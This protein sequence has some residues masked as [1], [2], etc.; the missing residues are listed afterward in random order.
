MGAESGT[1]Q[2]PPGDSK[3]SDVA[4]TEA[5]WATS[6]VDRAVARAT[7]SSSVRK[8]PSGVSWFTWSAIGLNRSDTRGGKGRGSKNGCGNKL[9]R[10][11]RQ[12]RAAEGAH[13][14]AAVAR[15]LLALRGP[16]CKATGAGAESGICRSLCA[17]TV[18]V[19]LIGAGA[20]ERTEPDSGAVDIE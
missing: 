1:A 4:E 3:V 14:N 19:Q 5:V 6:V 9:D 11:R 10:K 15:A 7:S 17:K 13:T 20:T 16:A 12:G 18:R 2:A 8:K